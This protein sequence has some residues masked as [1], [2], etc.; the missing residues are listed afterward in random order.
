MKKI[1]NEELF[2][3][4][5]FEQ[6]Y[7]QNERF[8][9]SLI[10]RYPNVEPEDVISCGNLAFSKAL[11]NYSLDKNVK[12][13]TYISTC[14]N[15]EILMFIRK[16]KR[17]KKDISLNAAISE[18][19]DGNKATLEDIVS[20]EYDFEEELLHKEDIRTMKEAIL[21]LPKKLKTIVILK[22]KGKTQLEIAKGMNLTQSYISRLEKI[23]FKKLKKLMEGN[24]MTKK[25]EAFKMF[26]EGIEPMEVAEKLGLTRSTVYTY[27]TIYNNT[28]KANENVNKEPIKHPVVKE[29]HNKI[30]AKEIDKKEE[31]R[32][33]RPVLL[34]GEVMQYKILDS[35]I[36][37][38]NGENS[39]QLNKEKIDIF[40]QELMEL[41]KAI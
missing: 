10:K 41:K 3:R 23:A 39:I 33:L 9:Y 31:V 27:K 37:I 18:D 4:G 35:G 38:V 21:L 14:I 1:T 13:L 40:I 19:K 30:E 12:F 20:D 6:L 16:V 29:I 24:V 11:N 7:K 2:E 36:N 22:L 26:A 15:N 17:H 25:D 8:I 32:L 34:Q 28:A 5:E